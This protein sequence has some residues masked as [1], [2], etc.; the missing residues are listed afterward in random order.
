[1]GVYFRDPWSAVLVLRGVERGTMGYFRSMRALYL[2]MGKRPLDALA[3]P[4]LSDKGAFHGRAE[5][6]WLKL[7]DAGRMARHSAVSAE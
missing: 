4:I 6:R 5:A 3:Q 1:V 7:S 2:R